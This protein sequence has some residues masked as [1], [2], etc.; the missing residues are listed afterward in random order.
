MSRTEPFSVLRGL[1]HEARWGLAVARATVLE[2]AHPQIGAALID[3]STFVAHPWRRLRNTVLSS[4]R[5]VDPDERVRDREAARLNRLHARITGMDASGRPY[6]ALDSSARAWVVATLFESTV[7][8]YRLSGRSL[9]GAF[10]S[11][12][13][14]DFRSLLALMEGGEGE[15]PPTL[16]AFWPYYDRMVEECLEPTEAASLIL[17][18]LFA[19]VPAPPVLRDRPAIWAAVRGAAAPLATTVTAASLPLSLRERLGLAELPGARTLTKAAYLSTGL[20][21]RVLPSQW[22]RLETVMAL[23]DPS[24]TADPLSALRRHTAKAGALFRLLTPSRETAPSAA[25]FFAEVLDQTGNGR[26][27]WPDLAAMAREIATRLDLDARGE[28]RLFTAFADWWHELAALDGDGDGRV[29]AEE[30]AVSTVTQASPALIRVAEVLFDATD[31]DDDEVIDAEEYRTLFRTAFT[32]DPGDTSPE[33]LTR[34]AFVREFL[35][36]MAGRHHSDA[37][38]SLLTQA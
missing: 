27:D 34:A 26:L 3:N 14:G 38:E 7:T 2:A 21:S 6:T 24:Y 36:F 15:L 20:A 33:R 35:A 17:N 4:Q 23:F 19:Q 9:D 8:M 18:R 12:L 22:T 37:Y 25:R 10:L 32:H 31:T 1:T 13:Y 29:T 28:D 16:R 30:Y 5:L 11:V